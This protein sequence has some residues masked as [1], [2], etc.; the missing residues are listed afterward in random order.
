MTRNDGAISPLKR[1]PEKPHAPGPENSTEGKR[2]KTGS[3]IRVVSIAT[4]RGRM[5]AAFG[6]R[7]RALAFHWHASQIY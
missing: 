6:L 3:V 5:R 4:K 7:F 2:W 1:R